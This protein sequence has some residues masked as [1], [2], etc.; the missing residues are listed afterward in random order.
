[1]RVV[2][3]LLSKKIISNEK[4]AIVEGD[5]FIWSDKETA[6]VL[7]EFFNNVV[8]NLNMPQFNQ[9]ESNLIKISIIQSLKPL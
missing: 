8:I 3:P 5:K 7:N 9:I 6:K 1:M 2:K 4:I